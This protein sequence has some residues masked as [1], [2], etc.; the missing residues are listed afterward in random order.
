MTKNDAMQAP[1]SPLERLKKYCG[2]SERGFLAFWRGFGEGASPQRAATEPK[3]SQNPKRP[4]VNLPQPNGYS[5]SL[6]ALAGTIQLGRMVLRSR[7]LCRRG[8]SREH[9]RQ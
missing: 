2:H 3:Q 1:W 9:I 8:V 5:I 4:L 7:F 6:N